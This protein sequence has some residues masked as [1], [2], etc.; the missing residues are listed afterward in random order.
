MKIRTI[1]TARTM[2]MIAVEI[3]RAHHGESRDGASARPGRSGAEAIA[4]D[5]LLRRTTMATGA[6]SFFQ[7]CV[8]RSDD[9]ADQLTFG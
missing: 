4:L 8:T 6:K 2:A 3:E 9:V 5:L 1:M 7:Y